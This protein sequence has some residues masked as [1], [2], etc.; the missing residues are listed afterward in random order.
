MLPVNLDTQILSQNYVKLKNINMHNISEDKKK[1]KEVCDDFES[2]FLQQI[3]DSSL[4]STNIAGESTGSEI[5]KGL[6]TEGIA[7][8]SNGSFGLSNLLFEHLSEKINKA[9]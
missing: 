4:K 9:K 3:L 8:A 7:K 2:F 6:Y 1:L 5:I